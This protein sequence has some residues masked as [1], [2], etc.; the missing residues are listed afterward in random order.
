MVFGVRTT[1]TLAG[2]PSLTRETVKLEVAVS[3][4]LAVASGAVR[5]WGGM[6]TGPL[7]LKAGREGGVEGGWS[8]AGVSEGLAGAFP[9]LRTWSGIGLAWSAPPSWRGMSKAGIVKSPGRAGTRVK[10]TV[11]L[12]LPLMEVLWFI[13]CTTRRPSTSGSVMSGFGMSIPQSVVVSFCLMAPFCTVMVTVTWSP[14]LTSGGSICWL[15]V[16]AARQE[17]VVKARRD[18]RQSAVLSAA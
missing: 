11:A 17:I 9:P 15:S 1:K 5:L 8:G 10:I 4:E 18:A 16:A 3:A 2:R 6:T 12:E 7:G 13:V 14:T